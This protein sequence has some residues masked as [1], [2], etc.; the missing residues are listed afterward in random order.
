MNMHIPVEELVAPLDLHMPIK[1][2]SALMKLETIAGAVYDSFFDVSNTRGL[3]FV[4]KDHDE[5]QCDDSCMN[6][7]LEGL[8]YV[9]LRSTVYPRKMHA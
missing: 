6:N 2:A 9:R 5:I 1:T 7:R 3:C 8:E 4:D